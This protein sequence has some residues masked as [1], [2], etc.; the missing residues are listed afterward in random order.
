MNLTKGFV[1]YVVE[2]FKEYKHALLNA[3]ELWNVGASG[4]EIVMFL[5][6]NYDFIY[7]ALLMEHNELQLQQI[8]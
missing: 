2:F 7:E 5:Y 1:A 4:N 6:T 3:E 8:A